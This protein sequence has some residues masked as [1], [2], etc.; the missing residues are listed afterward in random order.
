[1][2]KY[3]TVN[4]ELLGLLFE[5]CSFVAGGDPT[6]TGEQP[7]GPPPGDPS[8]GSGAPPP[9]D[10]S[11]GG[12][13]PPGDPSMGGGA[14][15]MDPSM[16]GGGMP[17]GGPPPGGGGDMSG[18][19]QQIA[20]VAQTTSGAQPGVKPKLDV[21]VILYQLVRL[22]DAQAKAH[23]VEVGLQGMGSVSQDQSGAMKVDVPV[24]L[25]QVTKA[26][27]KINDALGVTSPAADMIVTPEDLN[28]LAAGG[29]AGAIAQADQN[30]PS[31]T[32]G[33]EQGPGSG[34][35]IPP[36]KPIQG[37]GPNMAKSSY[38]KYSRGVAFD[39]GK[40]DQ[41]AQ[42]AVAIGMLMDQRRRSTQ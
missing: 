3:Q 19:M 14:P 13:P 42:R 9:D 31:P 38:D 27:A 7:Q 11:M 25:Q 40:L 32:G 30:Q 24:T 16:M 22:V 37:A 21:N 12:A 33:E 15:P 2:A 4:P 29:P 20:Q 17:P 23:G 26:L 10:P 34:S 39:T 35:A 41:V 8:M 5:K 36:I 18:L 6:M 28:A 1:M